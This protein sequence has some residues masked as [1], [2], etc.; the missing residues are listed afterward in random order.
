MHDLVI[1]IELMSKSIYYYQKS[2]IIIINLLINIE[3]YNIKNIITYNNNQY[4]KLSFLFI[5]WRGLSTYSP[6]VLITVSL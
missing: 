5:F 4:T 2:I 3:S 1:G 6:A